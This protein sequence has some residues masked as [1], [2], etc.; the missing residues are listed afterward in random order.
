VLLKW[1]RAPESYCDSRESGKKNSYCRYLAVTVENPGMI[2]AT[3]GSECLPAQITVAGTSFV[4]Y[5]CITP[6][7]MSECYSVLESFLLSLL[8]VKKN[9]VLK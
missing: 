3:A 5:D 6:R 1:G 2:L 8:S 9:H 4:G 7:K